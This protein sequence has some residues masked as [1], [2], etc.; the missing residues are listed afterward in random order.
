MSSIA[1]ASSRLSRALSSLSERRRFAQ[2]T[3]ELQSFL[4]HAPSIG[5]GCR[6]IS[7]EADAGRGEEY[8]S[9]EISCEFIEPSGD[10]AG[11]LEFAEVAFDGVALAVDRRIDRTLH[12]AV[13]LGGDVSASAV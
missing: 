3:S 6:L 1:S 11:V 5:L 2:D 10:T 7:S 8:R 12:F 4:L 9:E 13:T